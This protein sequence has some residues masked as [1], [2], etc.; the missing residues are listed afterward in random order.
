ML[1][2]LFQSRFIILFQFDLLPHISGCMCTFHSLDAQIYPSIVL[3]NGSVIRVGERTRSAVAKT[4]NAVLV[5]TKVLCIR[6][7][8]ERA[9]VLVDNVPDDFVVLHYEWLS[10]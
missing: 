9:E 8:L 2:N 6:S 10:G 1:I 5:S 7:C 3:T 4:C